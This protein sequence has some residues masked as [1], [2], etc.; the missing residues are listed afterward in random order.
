MRKGESRMNNAKMIHLIG[1]GSIGSFASLLLAIIGRNMELELAFYDFDIVERHNLINQLYWKRDLP[2]GRRKVFK[3]AALKRVL[4]FFSDVPVCALREKVDGKTEF[5]GIVV[6]M[7]DKLTEREEIFE[8][9]KY[10]AAV[11]LYIDARSGGRHAVV[12]PVDPPLPDNVRRYEK[13]LKGTPSPAPCADARTV[14][15][16]FLIAGAIGQ[17]I[18]LYGEDGTLRFCKALLNIDGFP[19]IS[20]EEQ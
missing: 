4:R 9:V 20:S 2:G 3:V 14:P 16:L 6:V 19:I 12:Y 10:N 5:S 7:V 13:T 11:P 15:M 8:A 1:S 17:F 18:I